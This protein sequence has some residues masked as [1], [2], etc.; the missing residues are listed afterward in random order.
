MIGPVGHLQQKVVD[1]LQACNFG[2]GAVFFEKQVEDETAVAHYL[3]D[4]VY[5][6]LVAGPAEELA[7]TLIGG[8]WVP[9]DAENAFFQLLEFVLELNFVQGAVI[10]FFCHT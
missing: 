10:D 9:G 3:L 8:Q 6:V 4:T 7:V 2:G 5:R 1:F